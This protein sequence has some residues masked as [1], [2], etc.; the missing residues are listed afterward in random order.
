MVFD[1]VFL[2]FSSIHQ[3]PMVLYSEE[4]I[5]ESPSPAGGSEKP[6]LAAKKEMAWEWPTNTRGLG[7][8]CFLVG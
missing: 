3:P 2:M 8:K 7:E 6:G 5:S 4:R 1:H